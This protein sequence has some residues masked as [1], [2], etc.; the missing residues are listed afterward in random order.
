MASEQSGTDGT[1]PTGSTNGG[2]IFPAL[3][4]LV[5]L[6]V[7]GVTRA[8]PDATTEPPSNALSGWTPTQQPTGETVR[9]TLDFGNGVRKEFASL[10]W[11][12]NMT[13]A[14][15]LAAAEAY[16]PGITYVQQGVGESGFLTSLDGLGNEGA[17]GRNWLYRVDDRHAHVSFCLEK[18]E[19]GMHV[20][21][22]FTDELYNAETDK[23]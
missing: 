4:A 10:A 21:W 6:V 7:Y 12:P 23:N 20:L 11:Q 2:W 17:G 16:R 22:T 15:V 3:L 1:T 8:A 18:V 14:D 9:L 5:L 19:P 13:V